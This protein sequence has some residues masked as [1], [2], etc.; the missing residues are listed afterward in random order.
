MRRDNSCSTPTNRQEQDTRIRNLRSRTSDP[1][2]HTYLGASRSRHQRCGNISA[3][4]SRKYLR[5]FTLNL[6]AKAS[7]I[8]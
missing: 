4:S 6:R 3:P 5:N 1:N 7:C 2:T 8:A